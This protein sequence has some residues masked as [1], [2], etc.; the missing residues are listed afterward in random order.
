[1]YI[2][3][4]T[5]NV[6]VYP[7]SSGTTSTP[8]VGTSLNLPSGY[9]VNGHAY[10]WSATSFSGSTETAQ[11]TSILYF[12]TPA[13]APTPPTPNS[14]GS[15]SSPGPT[16]TTLTPQ[17]TWSTVSGATGY[18]LYIH[19]VTTNVLVYPNSSG[20]TSTPLTGTSFNLPSGYM[21]NGHAYRWSA[22]SFNGSAESAQSTSILYFQ[23]S[24]AA[25][26]P[27]TP[28]SPGNLSSP[29]PTLTT[30]TP[31]F[32]WSAVPG[33][34]GYGLYIRDVTTNVLVYP[35]SSGT[36]STP[37]TG[38]SFNLPSGYLVDG[39]AYRWSATS[40][41]GSAESAQS[42]SILYFQTAVAAL[43]PPT[44]SSPGNL[45][46][47]GPTLTTLTP[48]FTWSA[49]TG[50]TGYGVY[51]RDMT[52]NALVYP[53]SAG[54]TSTPLTG[55]SLNLPSGYLVDGHAYRWSATSFNGST[56]SA[57]STSILYFQTPAVALA[58]PTPAVPGSLSSPGP[59]LTTLTPQF[60]WSAVTG[61]TGY[62][63]YIRD[64]T[65]NVLVYPNS[66]GT[67]ST[68]LTG[69]SLNLPSGYLVDGHA[70][71]WSAT[72]FNGS[73]ESAQSTSILYF[74]TAVAAL[75]PPTPSSPG[76]LSSPGPTL[77]TLTPQ[78][79]WSAVTGATGY[80]VY[81]RDV[82]ANVL[83][84]PNSSGT[85]STPLT[86]TSLN[87]PSGYLVDGHAYRWS[88]TTFNGSSESAQST[89]ILYFQT[90]IAAL[91]PP[92]PS[93]P[94]NGLS[95]GPTLTT[96]T[97]QFTWSAVTGATGY[98]VYIR[99]LTTNVL[100]YPNAAGTTS[101]PLTG[102]SL[103]LSSGYLVNGHSYRWS[104]TSF[105]GST[106]SAQSTS[107][108]YF[109]TPATALAPPTPTAP[110]NLSSPGPTLTTL[111]PQFTWSAVTGA[112]G[113]GVYIRDVTANILVYPN[114]S[115]TT[116]TPLTGTSL[117]LPSGYLVDGHA[118]RWS[119]TTFN[120]SSESAQ[121]TSILYF[122]TAVAALAP[123]TPSSPGNASSPGPTLTTLTP[124]FT[125]SAVTGATGYGVY[126]RDI[127]TNALV[128]PNSAGTTS[129]PLTGTSLS[130]P[131]GYLVNGHAYR[132]SATS[133][134]GS[135]ESG[136][137]ANIL[138]FQ[139]AAATLAPPT[140]A[141]PGSLTSPGPTL[142]TLTPQ[143]TWSAVSGATG[144]GVYI[145]DV[146]TNVLVYPNSSGTTSAPLTGT[147]LNLPSGYLVDGHA[148]RW[149]ATTFNG[150]SE[151]AQSTSIL[152]F[153]TAITALAPPTPSTPGNALS[154]G[155]TL[156]TLTPQF[157]W[158][159]ITGAT[160]YG[161]Y[162]R[163]ITA[164]ALVYPNSAGTT[165]TPLTG[166]S[167][168]LPSGYL[169]N[170]HA[171][172][173]SATSFNGSTESGQSP[174][175]LYF[176]TA[177]ATPT[178][179]TL[180]SPGSPTSPGPT[181]NT[182]TPQFTWIAVSG[183]TGYGVY[184]RDLTANTL[185]YP[186]ASGT[187]STP[188]A[189]TSFNLPAG[190]L[191]DGHAYRW[192]ATTFSGASESPQNPAV[193]FFTVQTTT[194]T[195]PA[196]N[197]SSPGSLTSPGPTLNTLT[198]QFTWSGVP[199]ATGYGLYIR[200]LTTN[201]LIYPNAAGTTSPPLSGTSLNLPSG[202]LVS[203]HAYR[204]SVTTFNGASESPQNPNVLFFLTAIV[205][206]PAPL[207]AHAAANSASA[208]SLAWSPVADAASYRITN[209]VLGTTRDSITAG[210][211]WD[212]LNA[213]TEYCFTVASCS[214]A[215]ACGQ[216]GPQV[217]ATTLDGA[218]V[219][220]PANLQ[221]QAL[222]TSSI[223]LSWLSST[224]ASFYQVVNVT[225][226]AQH[227]NVV[228]IPH[229]WSS[230]TANTQYCFT[231]AACASTNVCSPPTAQACTTTLHDDPVQFAKDSQAIVPPSG[232]AG[233]TTFTY[234]VTLAAAAAP[235]I[236]LNIVTPAGGLY[237]SIAMTPNGGGNG[238]TV[239]EATCS[240][241]TEGNYSY[242]FV[243]ASG[244][245]L[246]FPASGAFSGPSVSQGTLDAPTVAA[247]GASPSSVLLTWSMVTGVDLYR[248]ERTDHVGSPVD[249]KELS[250]L[251]GGLAAKTNYCFTVTAIAGNRTATSKPA[252]A[253][254]RSFAS[255]PT[256]LGGSV[257]P[258][259]GVA[260]DSTFT[261]TV[262]IGNVDGAD[263]TT[264]AAHLINRSSGN[265]TDVPL[266][267]SSGT[268]VTGILFSSAPF[269]LDAGQYDVYFSAATA[270]GTA[271]KSE[272]G[273]GPSVVASR[274]AK[275]AGL[276]VRPAGDVEVI[277]AWSQVTGASTYT[278]R[279]ETT[280]ET[281]SGL[282]ALTYAWKG[283]SAEKKYC[284][285]IVAC[286]AAGNCS[287]PSDN[288]CATTYKSAISNTADS[289]GDGLLDIWETRGVT[290]NGVFVPLHEM[291]ADP[292]KPDVFV[293]V[294]YMVGKDGHTHKPFA[295][296][297]AGVVQTFAQHGITLH[298]DWG[299]EAIMIPSSDA[300]QG[301]PWGNYSRSRAIPE[302]E[303]LKVPA[304]GCNT[305]TVS[306]T[307]AWGDVEPI[308]NGKDAQGNAYFPAERRPLF[309]FA[310]IAHTY[311]DCG[312][313]GVSRNIPA[314]DFIVTLAAL[315]TKP[316]VGT[317]GE[318]QG[319]FM[320][321]LG[322]NLGLQHGGLDCINY[323]PN[324]MSIM[325]YSYQ[326]GGIFGSGGIRGIYDYSESVLPTLNEAALQE[327]TGVPGASGIIY[328]CAGKLMPVIAPSQVDWN[329]DGNIT[330]DKPVS[331]NINGD[332]YPD[333]VLYSAADWPLI[334]YKGGLIVG[335]LSTVV[336]RD[337]PPDVLL[338]KELSSDEALSNPAPVR[339]VVSA[340][341]PVAT[342][343][344]SGSVPL[345]FIV[346]NLGTVDDS[347]SIVAQGNG[348]EL[349]GLPDA[350]LLRVG[351]RVQLDV[352]ARVPN[353]TVGT[354]YEAVV[355]A[356]S[357]TNPL[358]RDSG[359]AT[360][361]ILARRHAA[362]PP[363]AG[364]ATCDHL[365]VEAA[366][367]NGGSVTVQ[368]PQNC[369]GGFLSGTKI[370]VVATALPGY[371]FAGW[372]AG[373]GD[374]SEVTPGTA[375][376]MTHG[377]TSITA[378]FSPASP[379]SLQIG[380]FYGNGPI[381]VP[382]GSVGN[383]YVLVVTGVG[384]D[385]ATYK[386]E[387]RRGSLPPGVTLQTIPGCPLPCFQQMIEGTPTASGTYTA[388]VGLSDATG[389]STEVTLTIPIR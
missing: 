177:T 73:S 86:G 167:I 378:H 342:V 364:P 62:G 59:T 125:W 164:N 126:I 352:T 40:F 340:A 333:Q 227:A 204:W 70:Y 306:P 56:E 207:D 343:A 345:A 180:T 326:L 258:P 85:T 220:T 215:G 156:T 165:S 305:R 197:L 325:N 172:R 353:G 374:L 232:I 294:D 344:P 315:S 348:L 75:A 142:T 317:V 252:C 55:T 202:Y 120:G 46:S 298:V 354:Q 255:T 203:G 77:T 366:P 163:D 223:S 84:Y 82:T 381:S 309:H 109:Q 189:G 159:A 49:I 240:L 136:Q 54:T 58:P 338:E 175:I 45:S 192:S 267:R 114:S 6:L 308:K 243:T 1:V 376:V 43:A 268:V 357:N 221:A 224:G 277:A 211:V 279:N 195:L 104:A 124:Q 341:T 318:L 188:L 151:S 133:F 22:T 182:L 284:L 225:T 237:R 183:A 213:S 143:F 388:T 280:N 261:A 186:N 68:P 93:S 112:T 127:T 3:D 239:F 115:G 90:A 166:T 198:P 102:T 265:T 281:K 27:P 369:A 105:N 69:T 322:H 64:V 173:W 256:F 295:E 106:E 209:L 146:T 152:Y 349:K 116:S 28:S 250:N 312:S 380:D 149:S 36:T 80:G 66:S 176:Q 185:V 83:V 387:L 262:M 18:G 337:T 217:C 372:S 350:I 57:Q 20:T 32:T 236:T 111:T 10:R 257:T 218:T 26:T 98:G 269:H 231:V 241:P 101:T 147:S 196:P 178:A 292:S 310:L 384:G 179:P 335:S 34:T 235:A 205:A 31:Q 37:L 129:T 383:R 199:G 99:D 103:S 219:T 122:Q 88:A 47:P 132:W 9:L 193:L 131:S 274:P 382:S 273:H 51:I 253:T 108:L 206:P 226:G 30:L 259:N 299:G 275:P 97:P 375:I 328:N 303:N 67:T 287:Q 304:V 158:S 79:I 365:T 50:A 81:I 96:L 154:P 65:A 316:P 229:V 74:Q 355:S 356:V 358:V 363:V 2:R 371:V 216:P 42:T 311:N 313:S 63:V 336:A 94:G 145:R 214:A 212:G 61:A 16:L 153:Q 286:D 155:P 138:Y 234:R 321:E 95:P 347:Y 19:D 230:L 334:R 194:T 360:I 162:I 53:N 244:A 314:S 339:V 171:Y 169:L 291:G 346:Q 330:A 91:A 44:P 266:N 60:T 24:A 128:Y 117:N 4:L 323:K 160:G 52:T 238:A 123:P 362:P 141:A 14:P 71:R 21:V 76:S 134:N 168:N 150:S 368:T 296:A 302:V 222:G 181:L 118:Y 200:D 251:Y 110:G 135:T 263:I 87:L 23:T 228:D 41:N 367:L 144:Y 245:T 157:T 283:L 12:Q 386:W 324:Y 278:V 119:A 285:S 377:D 184:I 208:I 327:S 300:S 242:Y 139:T 113:Y 319:T 13:A 11:S 100:V 137:S 264:A 35:N 130:L 201:A 359:R 246:R 331:A 15:L 301:V 89:S 38:T 174:S 121:S 25:P 107:I 289:D 17:F 5:T 290:V 297:I 170:G 293:Q 320:H 33:A 260:E 48:Q 210:A 288:A 7:N 72:T 329:C 272:T 187:T 307:G 140:P 92:T 39:H 78:F 361:T 248:I 379:S 351:E 161:V 385:R 270:A 389:N 233:T 29:G 190:Y 254:T 332:E 373:G 249:T 8:I 247:T 271:G 276:T 191:V 282:T 370:V 148:Y